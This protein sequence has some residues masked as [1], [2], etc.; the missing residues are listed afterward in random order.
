[1]GSSSPIDDL[2]ESGTVRLLDWNDSMTD[3]K[4]GMRFVDKVQAISAVLANDPEIPV[5]NIIQEVQIYP[6]LT[7][8][9]AAVRRPFIC[10]VTVH[11]LCLGHLFGLI[12]TDGFYR[13]GDPPQEPKTNPESSAPSSSTLV[14]PSIPETLD[15]ILDGSDEEE[16]HPEVQAQALRDYQLARD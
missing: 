16:E 14:L 12:S 10:P 8:G 15:P 11:L 7:R 4:L 13:G 3:I 9:A 2:V 6:S 1:M 5:S